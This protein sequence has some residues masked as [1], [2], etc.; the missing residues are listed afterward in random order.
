MN[1]L[2]L[3]EGVSDAILLSYY[4]GRVCGWNPLKRAPKGLDIHKSE[5]NQSVYWYARNGDCLLIC[6]VGG[7]DNFGNFFDNTVRRPIVNSNAFQRIAVVTDRDDRDTAE[8][9]ATL[10]HDFAPFFDNCHD[11]TWHCINYTDA[12]KMEQSVS[13]LLLVIPTNQQGALENVIMDA[14]S[15]NAYDKN[16]VD[17]SKTFVADIRPEAQKYIHSNRLQLKADL[18]VIWAIQSPEKVFSFIDEQ[19]RAIPLETSA[20]LRE[21]FRELED[22]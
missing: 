9:E 10:S 13:T 2:I 21:C 6:G 19:L 16:I 12:F 18:S 20:T 22:I 3:C 1:S 14:I 17:R 8:I 15:E 11:R 7:K 4:L 5:D